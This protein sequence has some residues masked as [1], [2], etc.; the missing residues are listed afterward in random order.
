MLKTGE[1]GPTVVF[2]AGAGGPLEAWVRVQSEVSKF[3]R[4]ISYDRAGNGLSTKGPAPRD[5]AA[6]PTNSMQRFKMP[7]LRLLTFLSDI[8][9]A[10][11]TYEFLQVYPRKSRALSLWTLLKKI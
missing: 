5:G 10:D 3:A 8:R 11:L 9:W 2:E 1:A 4:T 6:S 7:T